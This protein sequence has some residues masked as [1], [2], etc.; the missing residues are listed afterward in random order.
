M[1][2]LC[3]PQEIAIRCDNGSELRLLAANPAE[4]TNDHRVDPSRIYLALEETLTNIK[5]LC[6][7]SG[8]PQ[9]IV[10]PRETL[11][12]YSSH[13]L[14]LRTFLEQPQKA[15]P[16]KISICLINGGGG[17][18]GDGIMFAPALDI[19]LSRLRDMSIEDIRLTLCTLLPGR[20]SSILGNIPGVRI[21]AMPVPLTDFLAHDTYADFSGMLTDPTFNTTHM[22]DLILERLGIDPLTIPPAAKEP[23]LNTNS[24]SFP[25]V[26][27]ALAQARAKAN[28]KPLVAAIFISS[29]TRTMPEAQFAA[30]TKKL[31]THYQPAIIFP[32]GFESH[33]FI[34]RHNLTGIVSDLSAASP[35]FDHYFA[36]LAGVDA[37]VS[38]DTSAVHIGAA[39]KK[40]TVALFNSIRLDTRITYSPT[41]QGIQLSFEGK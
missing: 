33:T 22:T 37:I 13:P 32:E 40:P 12:N 23:F 41:V 18:L 5:R 39:F 24:P 11:N 1:I 21:A 34:E 35:T 9:P 14:P 25:I 17:G 16:A 15:A 28:G 19:L 27:A 26:D 38:V 20:T 6:I 36:L 30:L 7:N 3:F 10:L 29:Y 31:A 2:P 8:L 4:Q